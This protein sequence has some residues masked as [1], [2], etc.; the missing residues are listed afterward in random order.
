MISWDDDQTK[1]P[2]RWQGWLLALLLFAAF[3][4]AHVWSGE[5]R[6]DC[7]QTEARCQ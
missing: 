6:P 5:P 2:P 1:P 4:L 7:L 3:A